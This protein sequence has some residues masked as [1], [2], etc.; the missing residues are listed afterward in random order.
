MIS[1]A[2]HRHRVRFPRFDP[3]AYL[4]LHLHKAE[5]ILE[6]RVVVGSIRHLV[7]VFRDV[8]FR[9][10]V[11]ERYEPVGVVAG[12]AR[13]PHHQPVL[14]V[15]NVPR[16][17]DNDVRHSGAEVSNRPSVK[18]GAG[19]RVQDHVRNSKASRPVGRHAGI[20]DAEIVVQEVLQRLDPPLTPVPVVADND[21]RS[22]RARP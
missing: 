14:A 15:S 11:V 22:R 5:P 9:P 16:V 8:S 7:L 1:G 3:W 19:A 13:H 6:F 17:D 2:P 12:P 4:S 20:D 18:S 21:D 10:K